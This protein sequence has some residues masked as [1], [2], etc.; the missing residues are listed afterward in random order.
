MSSLKIEEVCEGGEFGGL[1]AQ[2]AELAEAHGC[3]LGGDFKDQRNALR[4]FRRLCANPELRN[5]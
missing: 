5:C 4:K 3:G 2:E 1:V